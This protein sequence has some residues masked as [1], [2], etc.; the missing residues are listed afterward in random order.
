MTLQ[1]PSMCRVAGE[2]ED[3]VVFREGYDCLDGGGA[4][5]ACYNPRPD[6]SGRIDPC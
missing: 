2:E 5:D 3:L 1:L 4:A 6:E